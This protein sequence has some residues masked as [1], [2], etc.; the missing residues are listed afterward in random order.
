[1]HWSCQRREKEE[2]N[3]R[4]FSG[5]R[6]AFNY[7]VNSRDITRELRIALILERPWLRNLT[8]FP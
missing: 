2:E 7:M 4:S 3:E 6:L 5:H 8:W 1:L